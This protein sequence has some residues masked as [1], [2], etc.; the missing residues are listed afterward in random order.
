[1]RI[2]V[3]LL[4]LLLMP[5]I[6]SASRAKDFADAQRRAREQGADVL[7]FYHGSDWC[8]PGIQIYKRIWSKPG[9]DSTFSGM[10]LLD[11]DMPDL[12]E[13]KDADRDA[14]LKI[15]N[16][17]NCPALALLDSQGRL[18]AVR[19]GVP[20]EITP[21]AF[22]AL[23]KELVAVRAAR[24]A[25]WAAAPSDGPE[26]AAALGKG[27]AKM[28]FKIAQGFN[29]VRNEIKQLDPADESGYIAMYAFH[30]MTFVD[31][32]IIPLK[33]KQGDA[34]HQELID[35]LDAMLKNPVRPVWQQQEIWAMKSAIFASWEGHEADARTCLEKVVV[36]DPESDLSAG[37]RRQLEPG[38]QRAW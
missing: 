19:E 4:G 35:E 32:K 8:K 18:V 23:V 21:E 15:W 3:L 25:C 13:E 38:Y 29:E 12:S 36:L 33:R 17:W 7:V 27:L 16:P 26:R 1:M 20:G 2:R 24:D 34:T 37:A 5:G 31:K 9:M 10:V 11:I 22:V 6:G 28:D 30:A 14:L